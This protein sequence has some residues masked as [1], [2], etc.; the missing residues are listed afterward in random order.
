MESAVAFQIFN[1]PDLTEIV[2]DKIAAAQPP[3]LFVFADGPRSDADVDRCLAARDVASRV[4][5]ECD[6]HVDFSDVNLG[7]RR[8]L[9]T[10]L[11]WAF[12]H[13]DELIF[14]ED[15]DLPDPS[16]FPFCETLLEHYRD[17]PDVLMISGCNYLQRWRPRRGRSYHMSHLGS[18]WGFGLWKRAWA[19]YDDSIDRWE[20]PEVREQI[21][22]LLGDDEVFEFERPRFDRLL[23]D[24]ENRHSWDL[25]WLFTRLLR[26]GTTVVPAENLI[27]NLGY[28]G[29]RLAHADDPMMHLRLGRI[30]APLGF[31][32]DPV[33]RRFDRLLVRRQQASLFGVQPFHGRV[34]RRLA[35]AKGRAQKLFR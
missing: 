16:F 20:D 19:L 6:V 11:N 2:F 14:L 12:A 3:Q 29:G 30:P 9:V 25:I 22:E 13:V 35:G 18:P 10:G 28:P 5:W 23:A 15:D 34:R 32:S 17:D 1:R 7:C 4:S 27:R 8:R 21:R 31:N 33:D 24:P 26:G